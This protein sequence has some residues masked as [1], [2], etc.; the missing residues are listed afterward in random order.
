MIDEYQRIKIRIEE[1]IRELIKTR[2]RT[3]ENFADEFGCDIRTASRWINNGIDSLW[4]LYEICNFFRINFEEFLIG[5][6]KNET[7]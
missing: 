1:K 3:I 7:L 5:G 4:K 6:K 2:C